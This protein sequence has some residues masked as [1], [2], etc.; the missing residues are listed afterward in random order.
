LSTTNP[1]TSNQIG[2]PDD[3]GQAV[4][5]RLMRALGDLNIAPQ[6][7]GGQPERWST[8]EVRDGVPVVAFGALSIS[9]AARLANLL[10]DLAS[11]SRSTSAVQVGDDVHDPDG[12]GEYVMAPFEPVAS[13]L[14]PY[15][16]TSRHHPRTGW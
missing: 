6:P 11:S 2:A 14:E 5:R 9:T 8:L 1:A 10:E 4:Y 16:T 13:P 7:V 15:Q 3:P 12:V